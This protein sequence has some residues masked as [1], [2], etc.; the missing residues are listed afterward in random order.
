M[1]GYRRFAKS[2]TEALER[3][4]RARVL[5]VLE[6]MDPDFLE[7]HGYSPALLRKGLAGWPWR[8]EQVSEAA[9]GPTLDPLSLAEAELSEYTDAQLDELGISRSEIPNA[10]RCGRPGMDDV[11]A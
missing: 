7:V 9:K 11:A 5:R 8:L 10:V 4:G 1:K 3:S 6:G 2:L